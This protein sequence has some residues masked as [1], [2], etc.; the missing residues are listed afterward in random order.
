MSK[1]SKQRFTDKYLSVQDTYKEVN[2]LFSKFE[3]KEIPEDQ[4][5]NLIDNA[6][7]DI[8]MSQSI[9]KRLNIKDIYG[10]YE[11]SFVEDIRANME[12]MKEAFEHIYDT[13]ISIKL[14]DDLIE[15]V[16]IYIEKMNLPSNEYK[17]WANSEQQ[18]ASK[19]TAM[20]VKNSY[21]FKNQIK[22][23]SIGTLSEREFR[24]IFITNNHKMIPIYTFESFSNYKTH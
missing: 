18:L 20:L 14:Y 24:K 2:E 16:K 21:L 19:F 3:N 13:F 15:P 5:D 1:S 12:F 4:L 6:L 9:L 22:R 17:K 8:K 7:N 11:K 10:E 23:M